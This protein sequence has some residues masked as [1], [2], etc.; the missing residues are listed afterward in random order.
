MK[1]DVVIIHTFDNHIRNMSKNKRTTTLTYI[2]IALV[3]LGISACKRDSTTSTTPTAATPIDYE[4]LSNCHNENNLYPSQITEHIIGT[5][6]INKQSCGF[7][8]ETT[9]PTENIILILNDAGTYSIQSGVVILNEGKWGL[10]A[11]PNDN[12]WELSLTEPNQYLYG[13]IILCGNELLLS[14]RYIDGC[15]NYFI[16]TK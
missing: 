10:K 9:Y 14:H 7:S 12:R 13:D 16:R 8:P 3:T 1:L 11:S 5:W 2:I 15:D 4:R 6:Q